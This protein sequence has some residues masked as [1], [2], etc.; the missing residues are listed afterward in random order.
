MYIYS[1]SL[2]GSII[3]HIIFNMCG[4]LIIPKL[5]AINPIM[6]YVIIIL[7]IVCLGISILKMIKEYNGGL[8][9]KKLRKNLLK[10][11]YFN[12]F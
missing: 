11:I 2:V 3:V 5:V 7:G 1:E 4:I 10:N 12:K 8:I 9:W 6:E